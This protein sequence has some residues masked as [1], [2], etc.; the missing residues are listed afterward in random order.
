M[1]Q[2]DLDKF[3]ETVRQN[4]NLQEKLRAEGADPVL[5]AAESGFAI[6]KS[7]ISHFQSKNSQEL[8]D[9][10]LEQIGGARKL[11]DR[12]WDLLLGGKTNK[13]AC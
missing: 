2:E 12:F 4:P 1:S 7:E 5:I 13:Y 11:N 3:L 6:T 10:E 9:Q 8:S